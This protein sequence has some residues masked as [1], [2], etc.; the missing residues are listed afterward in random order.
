[1]IQGTFADI[2]DE[3]AQFVEKFK[4]K[5]TTDDCYT[6]ANIYECVAEWAVKR[7]GFDRS[8]IIRPFW[9]GME[10][11]T[12]EYPEGCVVLDNPPFSI[13]SQIIRFYNL[14]KIHYFL[15]APGLIL[16]SGREQCNHIVIAT[17]I[18]YENGANV[19]T[20]FVTDM[21]ENIIETACDLDRDL[22]RINTANQKAT[23]KQVR[24]VALPDEVLTMGRVRYLCAHGIDYAVRRES[25][26]YMHELDNYNVFGGCLLL[27]ERAA[28]ERAAAER[29]LL[30]DRERLIVQQLTQREATE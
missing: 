14:H 12:M 24:K 20:H 30:S 23:K 29:V 17:N 7:Y 28:A 15:F 26:H 27:S 1:M 16:T 3:Y 6:P 19:P 8:R 9:P 5:K 2:S 18:V 25:C 13:V 11:D 22:D 4:P 10:Y 21:G